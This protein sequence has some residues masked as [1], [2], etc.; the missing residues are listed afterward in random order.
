M[1]TGIEKRRFADVQHAGAGFVARIARRMVR[2]GRRAC[3]AARDSFID[4]HDLGDILARS[5][6]ETPV[7]D[8]EML[9]LTY[10]S[11]AALLNDVRRW[12]AYP[13]NRSLD[14][15]TGRRRYAALTAALEAQRAACGGQIELTFEVVYGHAWKERARTSTSSPEGYGVV[16]LE[17]ILGRSKS[18]H[19]IIR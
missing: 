5:G 7:V 4:M 11:P 17:N 6:F 10:R 3:A 2:R 15:L 16:K 13:C 1:A 19:H 14:G 18:S 12:G 9:T 8:M